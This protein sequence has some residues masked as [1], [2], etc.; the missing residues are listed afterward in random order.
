MTGLAA[1]V[2]LQAALLTTGAQPYEQAYKEHEESGKPLL[3]LVGA[4][5]CP[6]CVSMKTGTMARLERGGKLKQ[7]AFSI[8][9][10]D[11]DNK[12]AG[13]LMRGGSI[14]QLVLFTKTA[15]GKWDRQQL[16]GAQSEQT[17]ERLINEAVTRQAKVEHTTKT[18]SLRQ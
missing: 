12:I 6:A 14:P 16:T 10:T 5:W 13:G 11:R 4:D 15:D 18:T 2:L 7:V 17:I 3:V 8:V 1:T 9:N